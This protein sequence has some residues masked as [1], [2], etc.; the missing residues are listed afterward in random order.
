MGDVAE[1]VFVLGKPL[2]QGKG[3]PPDPA[4][5]KAPVLG[6]INLEWALYL[7]AFVGVAVVWVLVQRNAVVGWLLALGQ[8]R[9]TSASRPAGRETVPATQPPGDRIPA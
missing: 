7:A 6:P 8:Y 5:L 9:R 2:L 3:E 4:R 1:C